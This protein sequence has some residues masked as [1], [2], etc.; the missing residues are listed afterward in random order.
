MKIERLNENDKVEVKWYD[1]LDDNDWLSAADAKKKKAAL[2]CSLG[3]FLNSTN[4][5]LRI[6]PSREIFDDKDRTI[7]VI[8][9]GCIVSVKK[10]R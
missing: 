7:M 2:C 5:V 6:S 3:Y 1:I 10:L 4:S 8:P 9:R